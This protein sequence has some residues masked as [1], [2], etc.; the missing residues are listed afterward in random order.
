VG[1]PEILGL[2]ARG[3]GLRLRAVFLCLAALA[4]MGARL[5]LVPSLATV[6]PETP[7]DDGQ[8]VR[9]AAE[10][11]AL[12]IGK[13]MGSDA[14]YLQ[15]DYAITL[16]GLT[17]SFSPATV[18]RF[19]HFDQPA[20]D[21]L[22]ASNPVYCTGLLFADYPPSKGL[23]G[24]RARQDGP[25]IILNPARWH[26]W[27]FVDRASDGAFDQIFLLEWPFDFAKLGKADLEPMPYVRQQLYPNSENP[28]I[29]LRLVKFDP[30]TGKARVAL[31]QGELQYANSRFRTFS[32]VQGGKKLKR[33]SYVDL[34]WRAGGESAKSQELLGASITVLGVD[35]ATKKLMYRVN[36]TFVQ[37]RF[38]IEFYSAKG[39]APYIPRE[40]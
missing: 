24:S 38:A 2:T 26:R 27:C 28:A 29:A 1:A 25:F 14:A 36:S 40:D 34:S 23:L 21:G 39:L 9:L 19:N 5:E 30:K 3:R 13:V 18:L 22:A 20:P 6:V 12:V 8:T 7:A 35:P 31:D 33:K 15:K 16:G 10:G 37:Q 32:V 11:D 17:F 4:L